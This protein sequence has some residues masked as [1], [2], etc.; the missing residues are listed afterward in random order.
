[1]AKLAMKKTKFLIFIFSSIFL[2]KCANQ[3]PP[4]GGPIDRVPPEVLE[5]YPPNGTTNFHD[6][7]FEITFSEYIDKMSIMNALFISPEI[8]NL[9]YDWSGTSVEITFDDTLQE[10]TTYTVSVGSNIQDLNNKNNMAQAINFAFSTGPK[11]DK[12]KIS[13]RVYDKDPNGVMIFAYMKT[14]TFANPLIKKP[15][16]VS[17]VGDNGEFFFLGLANGDYRIFAVK[18][19]NTNRIYNVGEDMY[20]APYTEITLTDSNSIFEDL[21]FRLTKEDTSAPYIANITMTDKNHILIE[22]SE[23]IDSSKISSGNFFVVDSTTQKTIP[24]VHFFKSSSNKPEYYITISDSLNKDGNYFVVAKNIFDRNGNE[25]LFDSYQFTISTSPDTLA[26]SFKKIETGFEKNKIDYKVP[27]FVIFF[28]DGITTE[29]FNDAFTLKY[30]KTKLSYDIDKI[31]DASYRIKILNKLKPSKNIDLDI[32]NEL[33]SDAAG[34]ILDT[35]NTI[36]LETLTGREF[37]GVSGQIQV[38]DFDTNVVVVLDATGRKKQRYSTAMQKDK[39]FN[40]ERVLPGK[41]LIWCFIDS[42][43]NGKYNFG[44]VEPFEFSEQ[45]FSYPDTLELKARWPVGDVLIT[46]K[47]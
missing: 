18:E 23:G 8:K 40:F 46:D 20:G 34:N 37:S 17:Q 2:M 39:S 43:N 33:I 19:E 9:E 25:M 4:P 38:A 36:H 41:Y 21:N 13:G 14:D 3:L 35:V 47:F 16:N 6:D 28:N 27:S 42:D 11:L 15:K 30:K 26:P 12:G 31:D 45:F 10:N 29:N 5:V 32:D 22:Y 24:T 1:M 7:H 44:S